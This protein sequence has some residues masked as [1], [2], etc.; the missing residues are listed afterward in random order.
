MPDTSNLPPIGS[1]LVHREYEKKNVER[2]VKTLP[3]RRICKSVDPL[4][5]LPSRLGD[6]GRPAQPEPG[7]GHPGDGDPPGAPG[8]GGGR[9]AS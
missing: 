1:Y 4:Y 5:S 8:P 3:R 2:S 9:R 7:R 6:R